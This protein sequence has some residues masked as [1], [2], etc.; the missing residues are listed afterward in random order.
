[1]HQNTKIKKLKNLK[2]PREYWKILN[3]SD[4]KKEADVSIHELYIFFKHLNTSG[5]ETD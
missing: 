2:N 1:M 5:N 3:S 4:R